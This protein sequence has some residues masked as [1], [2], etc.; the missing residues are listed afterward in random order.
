ME[1]EADGDRPDLLDDLA[2]RCIRLAEAMLALDPIAA[3]VRD[4]DDD[5]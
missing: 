1:T 2:S 3:L 5:G 4:K